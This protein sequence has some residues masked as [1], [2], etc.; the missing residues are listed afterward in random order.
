MLFFEMFQRKIRSVLLKVLAPTVRKIGQSNCVS[1]KL[2]TQHTARANTSPVGTK[3][4]YVVLWVV[5]KIQPQRPVQSASTKS[6]KIYQ[7]NC[8]PKLSTQNTAQANTLPLGAKFQYVVLWNIPN[9]QLQ[10]AVQRNNTNYSKV[11]ERKWTPLRCLHRTLP[12]QIRD[13][14]PPYSTTSLYF[15]FQRNTTIVLLNS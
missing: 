3:F 8:F 5:P 1:Q 10:H 2:S 4:Q 13:Q 14:Q 15:I 12:E 9:K 7:R 6:S 11:G